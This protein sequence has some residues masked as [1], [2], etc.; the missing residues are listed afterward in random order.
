MM[1]YLV[2]IASVRCNEGTV[3]D[4]NVEF[5][6]EA[7]LRM[8]NVNDITSNLQSLYVSPF[9]HSSNSNRTLMI[10]PTA[11]NCHQHGDRF[12]H[13][14]TNTV[15][16]YNSVY[17]WIELTDGL[18]VSSHGASSDPA[19]YQGVR[20]A[21]WH[22]NFALQRAKII[23]AT[24]SLTLSFPAC[25]LSVAAAARTPDFANHPT[26]GHF[27]STSASTLTSTASLIDD[28][29]GIFCKNDGYDD[30]DTADVLSKWDSTPILSKETHSVF[31]VTLQSSDDEV[32]L[33]S[34]WKLSFKSPSIARLAVQELVSK[35]REHL[36]ESY[37]LFKGLPESSS[38]AIWF[39]E[40]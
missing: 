23:C 22:L 7:S 27:A 39:F 20:C 10:T 30:D 5:E 8:G 11:S 17:N 16:E 9:D 18:L 38:L 12:S 37:H 36:L 35:Q 4:L 34:R 6:A 21:A 13:T 14:S 25:P 40:P 33:E 24:K 2:V 1:M 31:S 26:S 28:Q 32:V 3:R 15:R 29:R 19:F